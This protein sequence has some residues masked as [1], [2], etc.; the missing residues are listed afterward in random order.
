[1]AE[2]N[3]AGAAPEFILLR[4]DRHKPKTHDQMAKK[5]KIFIVNRTRLDVGHFNQIIQAFQNRSAGE[6]E[7]HSF[8]GSSVT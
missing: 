5:K 6:G 4:D 8:T 3:N 7:T 1:M 2:L